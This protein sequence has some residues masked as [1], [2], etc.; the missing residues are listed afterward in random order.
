MVHKLS[1]VAKNYWSS[2]F[3]KTQLEELFGNLFQIS[4]HSPDTNPIVPVYNADMI[5]LHEPS[6][7]GEMQS[8]IRC[9]C[10]V[11]LMRRTI[12][13]D[14]LGRLKDIPKGATAAVINLND[15]MARE[16]LVNIYQLGIKGLH[17][18]TWCPG[19]GEFPECDYIITPRIYDFLPE[20]DKPKVLLGSRILNA[21]IIM[22]ILS[23]FNVDMQ[24]ADGI[25]K[26]HMLKTPN[27]FHGVNYLLENNRFLSVQWELLF[28]KINKAIAV[29]SQDNKISSMNRLFEQYLGLDPQLYHSLEE[30]ALLEPQ[31][32]PILSNKELQN[33]LVDIEGRKLV[34][35]T[36]NMYNKSIYIGKII[37]LEPYNQIQSV[38]QAVHRKIVGKGNVAKYTFKDILG[39]DRAFTKKIELCKRIA[40]SSS[41]VLIFGES[42]T[43]KELLASAIHN[44]SNRAL[45]PYVAVNCAGIPNELMESEF[46]GYQEGAF[47]GAKRGGS[48]GLFERA[49]GGTLFLDE[50]SEIPFNLQS[51]LLRAIQEKEIRK[52]GAN[53][54]ISIDVRII[55]ATNKD[56]YRM[57]EDNQFRRDLYYRL[58]VFPISIPPLRKRADDIEM[59]C[60]HFL[61]LQDQSRHAT[62]EFYLFARAYSW[63]GNIRELRNLIEFMCVTTDADIGVRNLPDYLK[64]QKLFDKINYDNNISF[65]ELLMLKSISSC[66]DKGSGSGRRSLCAYFSD[67]YFEIS[68]METRK[69]LE[70]L[71]QKGLISIQKGRTGCELSNSGRLYID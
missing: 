22:D 14:A 69:I 51:R 10:P 48:I 8:Y 60:R 67:N 47:T 63:P 52:V 53:Y 4:C 58:N 28:N 45:M 46:F 65:R 26:R 38:Q 56:L 9:D 49:N 57:V 18:T 29:I 23:Y 11:L 35:N 39:N 33:E 40:H 15:Y 24:V 50:I 68:E 5:L 70:D 34:L 71:E 66:I 20:S 16:T 17:M 43:G 27:F 21:D 19:S 42:G 25:I 1:I 30:I 7:L 54:N 32:E 13:A 3:L 61:A 64:K 36:D 44:Y 62:K 55:A 37:T 41:P 2:D 31:I 59:L 6:V 12:T